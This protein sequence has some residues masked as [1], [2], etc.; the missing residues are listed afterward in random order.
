MTDHADLIAEARDFVQMG[1]GIN[2]M[3]ADRLIE[4]LSRE[5]ETADQRAAELAA[6]VEKVLNHDPLHGADSGLHCGG[7]APCIRNILDSAPADALRELKADV[8]DEG[9]DAMAE[10]IDNGAWWEIQNPYQEEQS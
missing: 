4:D 9:A 3:E 10:H 8:W 5:L 6:V 1:S 7:M 2:V